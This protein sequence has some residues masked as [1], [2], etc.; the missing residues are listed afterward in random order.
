[1]IVEDVLNQYEKPAANK[2]GSL[3]NYFIKHRLKQLTEHIGDFI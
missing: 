2:Q 1:M 3:L